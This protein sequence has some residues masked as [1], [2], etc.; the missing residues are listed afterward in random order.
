MFC[1]DDGLLL[2]L[3]T[4]QNPDPS[5]DPTGF[6]SVWTKYMIR[7]VRG[8]HNKGFNAVVLKAKDPLLDALIAETEVLGVEGGSSGYSVI[9]IDEGVTRYLEECRASLT[10]A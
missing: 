1:R 2:A 7:N 8:I 3:R 5:P 9:A 10:G 6:V 4:H